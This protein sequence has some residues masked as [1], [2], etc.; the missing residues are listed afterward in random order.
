MSTPRPANL[1]AL[2]QLAHNISDQSSAVRLG[3]KTLT[4]LGSILAH[5]QEAALLSITELAE[6]LQIN[7][8]SLTRL[9]KKLGFSGFADF[10]RLLRDHLASQTS[11]FYS[12]QATQLLKA[13]QPQSPLQADNDAL[14][15]ATTLATEACH[16]IQ[17][18]LQLLSAD[19]ISSAAQTLAHASRVRIHGKRQYS[20]LAQ[21]LCYGLGLIR[22]DVGLLDPTSLGVAEGLAQLEAGDVLIT[23]C[24]YPYTR[25]VIAVAELAA[26]AGIIVIALTDQ[27]LSPLARAATH[28]FIV[29]Y[30]SNFFTNSI[31]AYFL[32]AEALLNQVARELEDTAITALEKREQ[33]IAALQ[34]EQS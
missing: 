25:E 15:H 28:S 13:S 8:S 20:A 27:E 9:V 30:R 1:E 33:Y 24:V 29:P 6:R 2:R 12:V 19:A 18:S 10:Q 3:D 32:L 16:T 23:A 5:P 26:K 21:F 7:P 34:I 14:A 22:S 4:A 11:S 31:S 17:H